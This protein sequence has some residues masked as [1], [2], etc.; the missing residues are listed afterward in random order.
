MQHY[1]HTMYRSPWLAAILLLAAP[2]LAA[3]PTHLRDVVYGHAAGMALTLDV[4]KPERPN[5]IGVLFMVSG[6]FSS[7]VA[8]IGSDPNVVSRFAPYLDRGDTVF[9]VGHGSQPKFTVAEI[10]GFIHRA[11]RFVRTHAADYGVD[12]NRLGI[13]GISSGG[14]LSLTMGTT[15]RDGD[16]AARDPVDRASSRVEAVACFCP[17]ADLVD[18]GETNRTVLEFKPVEFVWHVFALSDKPRE[19]QVTALREL[20]PIAHITPDDAPTLILH[21][22]QDELVPYEQ[23]PRFIARLKDQG[24]AAELI[25]RPGARH[26]WPTMWADFA[27][28][29][30]WFDKHLPP[31]AES[32]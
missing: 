24:V 22:D 8:A 3:E 6:G 29:A 32:N 2:V 1:E 20:S 25:T 14:Y 28:A 27:V 5:G 21:G 31:D 30:D 4:L 11:V 18:Y 10:V 12:R 26:T 23:A 19:E 16:P 17:P 15:G 9:L 13:S 7:D